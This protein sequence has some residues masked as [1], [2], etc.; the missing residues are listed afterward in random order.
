MNDLARTLDPPATTPSKGMLWTGRVIMALPALLLVWSSSMKLS[1]QAQMLEMYTG[2][3]GYP[4]STDIAVGVVELLCALLLVIPRTSVLGAI[5]V[6]GYLGGAVCAQ[7][8]IGAP[9]WTFLLVPVY[10]GVLVWLGL[11]LRSPALRALVR[12]GS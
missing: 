10:T 7:L 4:A 11:Y 9:L 3:F 1:G 6:T 5:L 8:R 2:K 12:A